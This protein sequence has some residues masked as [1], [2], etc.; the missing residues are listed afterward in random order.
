VHFQQH[1]EPIL[2]QMALDVG[3][4]W[5]AA[6]GH[7]GQDANPDKEKAIAD[8]I[9]QQTSADAVFKD[10]FKTGFALECVEAITGPPSPMILFKF[11]HVGQFTNN[12]KYVDHDGTVWEGKGQ[13]IETEGMCHA[14]KL[15]G[16]NMI[17]KVDVYYNHSKPIKTIADPDLAANGACP[18]SG[19]EGMCPLMG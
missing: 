11:R 12:A 3:A 16:M 1:L 19:K 15:P 14:L 13:M 7:T 10:V 6:G 18:M 2:K 4:K 8:P 17:Q 5:L 9:M